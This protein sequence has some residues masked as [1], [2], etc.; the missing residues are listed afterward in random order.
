[1]PQWS[2]DNYLLPAANIWN[3]GH[4][5][6]R[7]SWVAHC[8]LQRYAPCGL[9]CL[10][11]QSDYSSLSKK[12]SQQM[13]GISVV[14]QNYCQTRHD[15]RHCQLGRRSGKSVHEFLGGIMKPLVHVAICLGILM[16]CAKPVQAQR[17]ASNEALFQKL[18]SEQTTGEAF[19]RFLRLGKKRADVREFL[20]AR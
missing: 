3:E 10:C 17:E 18:E 12:R 11:L 4:F 6:H 16:S 7:C 2:G 14:C 8:G 9:F 19:E 1:M 15:S 20:S 5:L 13:P